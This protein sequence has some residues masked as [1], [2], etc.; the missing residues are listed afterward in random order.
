MVEKLASS[1]PVYIKANDFCG[2]ELST[3]ALDPNS[4]SNLPTSTRTVGAL[5][6]VE[7]FALMADDLKFVGSRFRRLHSEM[8]QHTFGF[9]SQQWRAWAA[10]FIQAAWRQYHKRKLR[11]FL[12]EEEDRLQDAL[13]KEAGTSSSLGVTIYAS[14]FATNAL[15]TLPRSGAKNAI[16]P[17]RLQPMLPQ[18]PAEPDF[19]HC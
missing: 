4:S 12:R 15:R 18:K 7:A 16:L 19:T 3:W 8:L 5:T 10:R 14:R 13:A 6:E 17:Q 2:E 11:K 1:T 9:Y